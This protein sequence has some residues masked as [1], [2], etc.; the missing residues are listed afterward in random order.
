MVMAMD[1]GVFDVVAVLRSSGCVRV[2]ATMARIMAVCVM[3]P[4]E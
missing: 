2:L 1:E 3:V 4:D